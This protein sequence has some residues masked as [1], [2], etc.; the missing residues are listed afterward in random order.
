MVIRLFADQADLL[1]GFIEYLPT[2]VEDVGLAGKID[3]V[4]KKAEDKARVR[5]LQQA[6]AQ[7]AAAGGDKVTAVDVDPWSGQQK[8]GRKLC[9]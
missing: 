1:R 2:C 7:Q 3:D 4:V 9:L 8:L 6:T 5:D